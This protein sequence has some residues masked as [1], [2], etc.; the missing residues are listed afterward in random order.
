MALLTY[1]SVGLYRQATVK[2]D[3]DDFKSLLPPEWLYTGYSVYK[4][5]TYPISSVISTSVT[6]TLMSEFKEYYG[7]ENNTYEC[8]L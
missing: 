4:T 7:L 5:G 1:K 3:K 8:E 2:C 6:V